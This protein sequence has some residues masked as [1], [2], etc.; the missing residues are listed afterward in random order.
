MTYS[1]NLEP[2]LEDQLRAEAARLGQTPSE[3]LKTIV[4]EYLRAARK[5]DPAYLLTRPQEEQDRSLTAQAG[6]AAP[7]YEEQV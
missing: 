5:A 6:R 2:K 7:V 3:F 1:I 4:E